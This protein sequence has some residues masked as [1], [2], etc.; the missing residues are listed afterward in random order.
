MPPTQSDC[1]A[2]TVISFQILRLIS[3]EITNRSRWIRAKCPC[4]LL[5]RISPFNCSPERT[6][7]EE[8]VGQRKLER[9]VLLFTQFDCFY[10]EPDSVR[11]G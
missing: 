9:S 8:Q 4:V 6:V 5:E 7:V 11:L 1:I 3:Y 10:L 2:V